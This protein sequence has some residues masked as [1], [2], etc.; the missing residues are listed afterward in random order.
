MN[1][2]SPVVHYL[3][4]VLKALGGQLAVKT[5]AFLKQFAVEDVGKLAIDAVT[6]IQSTMPDVDGPTK[7]DAAVAQFKADLATAGHDVEKFA[8]STLNWMIETALQTVIVGI[9]K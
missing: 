6:L 5:E 8:T 2:F 3:L 9:V 7:R 4:N 1:P